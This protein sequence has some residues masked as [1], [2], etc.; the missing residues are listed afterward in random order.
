SVGCSYSS[1]FFFSIPTPPPISTLFPYTTLFRSRRQH[2][3]QPQ[4]DRSG[5]GRAALRRRGPLR[6][7]SE[8]RRAALPAPVRDREDSHR[9]HRGGGRGHRAA[10]AHVE[11]TPWERRT[12]SRTRS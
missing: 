3:R 9:E 7:R 8:G 12:T 10:H 1:S 11:L 5:G 4:H 2:L 6:H